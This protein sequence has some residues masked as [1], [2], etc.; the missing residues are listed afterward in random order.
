M[1]RENDT[2]VQVVTISRESASF[3]RYRIESEQIVSQDTYNYE[4]IDKLEALNSFGLAP[5][6]TQQA[7][8]LAYND[9]NDDV[10]NYVVTD[11]D[12]HGANIFKSN[13]TEMIFEDHWFTLDESYMFPNISN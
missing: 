1:Y 12:F 7:L 10:I 5:E 8:G 3:T 6:N 9:I 11:I 2:K 13:Y 4:I